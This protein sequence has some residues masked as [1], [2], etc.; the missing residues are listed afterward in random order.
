MKTT[1]LFKF[2]PL[3]ELI[4][5]ISFP[6][7]ATLLGFP[8][9]PT[10]TSLKL[11]LLFPATTD[12]VDLDP[13]LQ[14]CPLLEALT[15]KARAASGHWMAWTILE[16]NQ[17]HDRS[18][19]QQQQPHLRLR[20]LILKNIGF[21]QDYLE[22][23]LLFTPHLKVLKLMLMDW[24]SGLKYDWVRLMDHIKALGITLHAVDFSLYDPNSG[25]FPDPPLPFSSSSSP[26]LASRMHE[27]CPSTTDWTFHASKV[28]PPFL[29]TLSLRTSFVTTM[30]LY[31]NTPPCCQR[32]LKDAPRLIHEYLC[33]SPQLVHLRTLKAPIRPEYMDLFGRG[34]GSGG[35]GYNTVAKKK[36][37]TMPSPHPAIWMCRGLETLHIEVHGK[38]N[39][40]V[41]FGYISRV[42]PQLE[43][44]YIARPDVCASESGALIYA[45]VDV[46]LRDG[47]CLLSRLRH[48]ERLS[49]VP[50]ENGVDWNPACNMMNLS[51]LLS[52]SST[53]IENNSDNAKFKAQRREEV[54]RWDMQRGMEDYRESTRPPGSLE[55]LLPPA[56]TK[57]EDREI[58][59]QL[60]HLGMYLDVE[61]MVREMD[62]DGFKPLPSLCQLSL[63]SFFLQRPKDELTYVLSGKVY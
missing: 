33:T 40:R 30:E 48:L 46:Q 43:E 29:K 28:T 61:E 38:S 12:V 63:G 10:L 56:G 42:L 15:V 50:N 37:T 9:P 35:D 54:E 17:Q 14:T 36:A 47:F 26:D 34:T 7:D 59:H 18:Q 31:W 55:L 1:T 45:T 62:S 60:R 24:N 58:W 2:S 3:R 32:D 41:L 52:S 51:W 5:R 39:P 8:F 21:P 27:I 53:S 19:D 20:S 4:L 22:N 6:L 44:L 16:Q 11:D 13:I 23:V 57:P 49:I 25:H